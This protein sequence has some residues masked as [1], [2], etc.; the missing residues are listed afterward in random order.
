MGGLDREGLG[1]LNRQTSSAWVTWALVSSQGE[2]INKVVLLK[3][4]KPGYIIC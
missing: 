2:N 4:N 3:H 1:I